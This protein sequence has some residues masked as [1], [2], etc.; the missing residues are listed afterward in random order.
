MKS[1][2]EICWLGYTHATVSIVFTLF[3]VEVFILL[4][5]QYVGLIGPIRW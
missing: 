3:S 1:Y 2:S 5:L 4:F